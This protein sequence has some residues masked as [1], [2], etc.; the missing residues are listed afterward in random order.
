MPRRRARPA[1]GRV[2]VFAVADP[3]F[4]R[5]VIAAAH[6]ARGQVVCDVHAHRRA[7]S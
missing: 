4:Y 6:G 5:G 3:D 1:A 2:R 7:S